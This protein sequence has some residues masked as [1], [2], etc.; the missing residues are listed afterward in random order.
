MLEVRLSEDI[1]IVV[2]GS[3]T[4]IVDAAKDK[5]EAIHA[6]VRVGAYANQHRNLLNMFSCLGLERQQEDVPHPL[7]LESANYTTTRSY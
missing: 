1:T 2:E 4:S 7:S 6:H 3:S 5:F